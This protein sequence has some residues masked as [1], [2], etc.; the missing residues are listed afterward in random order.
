[1]DFPSLYEI[2]LMGLQEVFQEVFFFVKLYH[3]K[4][5]FV[6][7]SCKLQD[8]HFS[9]TEISMWNMDLFLLVKFV[10]LEL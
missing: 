4:S 6:A 8:R 5:I 3:L 9:L 1:M 10:I 2:R 7:V